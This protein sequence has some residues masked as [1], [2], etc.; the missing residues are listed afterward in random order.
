MNELSQEESE[1][2]LSTDLSSIEIHFETETKTEIQLFKKNDI[3]N[4][5][6]SIINPKTALF[7]ENFFPQ[8]TEKQ[9][10][11][12]RWQIQNSYTNFKKLSECLDITN[13]DNFDFLTKSRKLPLRIT[14]Y[15]ASLLYEKPT[16]YALTKS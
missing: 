11:S 12:W 9:W 3:P 16:D 5:D 4:S 10:N 15:Y 2:P 14:P 13:I 7:K 8:A 6:F 1:P